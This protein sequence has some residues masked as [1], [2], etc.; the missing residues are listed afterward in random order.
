MR[1]PKYFYRIGMVMLLAGSGFILAGASGAAQ[2][3]AGQGGDT[4]AASPG[5]NVSS[6]TASSKTPAQPPDTTASFFSEVKKWAN[7]NEGLITLLVAIIA[8]G[9]ALFLYRR[10]RKPSPAPAEKKDPRTQ[11]Q[12]YLDHLINAHQH[13]PVAGFETNLRI[14]IPL[15]KVYVTLRARLTEWE[16]SLGEAELQTPSRQ[17]PAER[18]LSVQEALKLALDKQYHG[19]V[20]LGHPGSG[21]TTLAKYFTLCFADNRAKK[22]LGLSQELLPLL[23]FLRE[24]DPSKTLVENLLAVLQKYDLG[25]DEPFFKSYLE[26]GRAIVLLDGLDEVP[27]EEKRAAVSRWIHHQHLAFPACPLIVTSRFSGYRGEAVLQEG[28]YLRL[29]IQDFNLKEVRQFI[30]NWLTAVETHLHDDSKHWRTEAKSR[31]D[32]LCRRIEENPT[33]RE[34]AVNPLMLQIIALVHRD[35]GTLPERRV[36]LYQECTDVLLERWDATKGLQVLLSAAQARQLL[37]PV[38]LWMHSVENRREVSKAEVLGFISPKIPQIKAGIDPEALLQSWQERSGIFKGEGDT[39]FFHHLSFQEYLSAEQIRNTRQVNILIKYFDQAWWRETTLL[40]MGLTN[41]PIFADFMHDLLRANWRNGAS[42]DFMLRCIGEALLKDETPFTEALRRLKRPEARYQ[43]LM[44]LERIFGNAAP[45]GERDA[46]REAVKEALKDKNN[47]VRETAR[48]LL[49]KWGEAPA[50]EAA[51]T[52]SVTVRG[53]K[54][55]L[56]QRLYNPHELNAEYILIPGAKEKIIFES[57]E[58]PAPD[59]PLYFAKYPVTNK[60]YRRFIDYLAGV[61]AIRESPLWD[62]L[63]REQFARRLLEKAKEVKGFADY[64]GNNPAKWAEKLRSRY[65]DEKRFNGEDQPVVGV[66]W[67]AATAYCHW[68]T[69]LHGAERMAHGAKKSAIRDPQSQ[70]SNSEIRFRLPTEQEWQWAASGGKREYPWGNETPD[71]TRANYGNKVGQ[72]TPVGAYPAGATPEGLMDMAGNVWEWME[73]WYK[74]EAYGARSLRGGSWSLLVAYLRC[75][76]RSDD[77]PV[78]LWNSFGFRVVGFQ[79]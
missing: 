71:D 36:E 33:L 57:T 25:L 59:Y 69:E 65:H 41:P 27:T 9:W 32:D 68:L 66:T 73:N 51:E 39:Y 3:A 76:A 56:P 55:Q 16:R 8:G 10:S 23:L 50:P 52:L 15:E 11:E 70:I 48:S 61:G 4:L 5:Q 19:M 18:D 60:L 2:Q 42:V 67:F 6:D 1:K 64:L 17:I 13:L 40:A 75:S 43:A 62:A 54:Q 24:I 72:T 58:K 29:D 21:K 37:Q 30:E 46:V 45:T 77:Y 79:S 78:N 63:P 22:N 26:K 49:V 12:R 34:L 38:A 74:D 20:I 7:S 53:K 14:P 44:G 35:R 28:A 47:S 31:A